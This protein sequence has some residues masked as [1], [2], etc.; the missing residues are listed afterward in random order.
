M[1]KKELNSKRIVTFCLLFT[2][3]FIYLLAIDLLKSR[4]II[5]VIILLEN[6]TISIF[7]LKTQYDIEKEY[8]YENSDD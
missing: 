5:P 6:I 1:T 8:K 4:V 3:I 7:T 2:Q